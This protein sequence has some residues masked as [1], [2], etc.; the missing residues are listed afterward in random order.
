MSVI[1]GDELTGW[2]VLIDFPLPYSRPAGWDNMKKISILYE[3]MHSCKAEDYYLDI[4][5]APPSR[6]VRNQGTC[7]HFDD[8]SEIHTVH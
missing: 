8:C 7:S 5:L 2:L 4:I 3:N 1:G 6:K